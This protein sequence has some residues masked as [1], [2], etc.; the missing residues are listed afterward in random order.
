MIQ[1]RNSVGMKTT[2]LPKARD[3]EALEDVI[4]LTVTRRDEM[5]ATRRLL[6]DL[7]WRLETVDF[8]TGVPEVMNLQRQLGR[9]WRMGGLRG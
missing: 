7:Q 1:K 8:K 2:L 5:M 6:Q 3:E 4:E 9:G